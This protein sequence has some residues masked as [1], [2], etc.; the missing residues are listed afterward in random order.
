VSRLFAVMSH[1][2][3]AFSLHG[4]VLVHEVRAELEYLFPSNTVAEVTGTTLPTRPWKDHPDMA[5]I[6]W[7]LRREDFR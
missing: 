1:R 2:G 3:E 5:G 7:P 6:F 4:K